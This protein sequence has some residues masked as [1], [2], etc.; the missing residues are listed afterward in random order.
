MRCIT[1]RCMVVGQSNIGTH[2]VFNC[3]SNLRERELEVGVFVLTLEKCLKPTL[4]LIANK[5]LK[6]PNKHYGKKPLAL[7]FKNV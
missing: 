3:W 5:F 2:P 1:Q 7:C 4:I 6:I